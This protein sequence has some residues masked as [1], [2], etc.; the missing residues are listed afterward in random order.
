MSAPHATAARA[1]LFEYLRHAETGAAAERQL[2]VER[3][4]RVS[5]QAEAFVLELADKSWRSRDHLPIPPAVSAPE[6]RRHHEF[7]R[8]V[9]A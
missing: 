4:T 2:A 8:A 7:F 6:P 9:R 3:M 5:G 1:R